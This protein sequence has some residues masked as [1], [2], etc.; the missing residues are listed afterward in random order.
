MLLAI[1][2]ELDAIPIC[3]L[4]ANLGR[5]F[6]HALQDRV[7]L[8]TA[9]HSFLRANPCLLLPFQPQRSPRSGSRPYLVSAVHT[10]KT[11]HPHAAAFRDVVTLNVWRIGFAYRGILLGSC[12]GLVSLP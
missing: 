7:G 11:I 12:Y 5:F 1:R 8:R 2:S 9:F 4:A 10:P 6:F 3:H